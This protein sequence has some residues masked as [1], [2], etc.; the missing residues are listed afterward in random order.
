MNHHTTTVHDGYATIRMGGGST[1]AT[2]RRREAPPDPT[3]T[4]NQ[5]DATRNQGDATMGV[6]WEDN[7]PQPE[8]GE[9]ANYI[10]FIRN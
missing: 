2:R 3:T 9:W 1:K 10:F 8:P 5:G 6:L 4:V 7:Q